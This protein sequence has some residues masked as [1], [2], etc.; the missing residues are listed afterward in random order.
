MIDDGDTSPETQEEIDELACSRAEALGKG[1]VV[2][3]FAG[4]GR[5]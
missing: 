1:V 5:A 2:A 3:G 4:S